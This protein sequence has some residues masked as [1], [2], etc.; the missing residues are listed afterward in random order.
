LIKIGQLTK[1]ENVNTF[2]LLGGAQLFEKL[3][4]ANEDGLFDFEMTNLQ[5]IKEL[6]KNLKVIRSGRSIS[7]SYLEL[8]QNLDWVN[9]VI[10]ENNFNEKSINTLARNV[11]SNF[12]CENLDDFYKLVKRKN[13]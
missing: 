7:N 8:F 2:R 1:K 5:L 9:N 6:N 13:K 4:N 3:K 10:D 12:V 11:N